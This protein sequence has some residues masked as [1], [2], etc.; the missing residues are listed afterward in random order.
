MARIA[1]L[2]A[3]LAG[4]A[5]AHRLD[6]EGH[7]VTVFEREDHI[8]GVVRTLRA[9]GFLA[10]T[11]A[12][13][14][15][16]PPAEAAA[17][18]RATRI[19]DAGLPAA[20]VSR[21]RWTLHGGHLIELPGSPPALLRARV[22]PLRARLSVLR[23]A[24]RAATPAPVDESVADLLRRRGIAR[25]LIDLLLD[26]FVGGVYAGDV[27]R[28]SARW[29]FPALHGMLAEHGSLVRGAIAGAR[30]RGRGSGS[31]SF[32]EGMGELPRRI[33]DAFGGTIRTRTP[34]E[35]VRWSGRWILTTAAGPEEADAV[36]CATPA[37]A[38]PDLL[39]DTAGEAGCELPDV[40]YNPV[41]ILTLG[42][43]RADVGHSLD[44]FGALFPT[45]AGLSTLGVLF[46]SSVFPG[47]A[48]DG[49]VSLACFVGGSRAPDAVSLPEPALQSLVLEEIAPLLD[50]RGDPVFSHRAAW[51][52]AIPQYLIGY[53]DAIGAWD[54]LEQAVPTLALCGSYRGDGI[55]IGQVLASG[56]RAAGRLS[57]RLKS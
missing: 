20:A 28:L 32:P 52:R 14:F 56:L 25:E 17:F 31:V 44:G 6:T 34:V 7:D 38:L 46:P 29:A 39:G 41:A 27:E 50:L 48:P 13:S 26:P 35:H 30:R 3:G 1:V 47:R 55:A 33:A 57:S 10:E 16:R 9:D 12:H 42:F 53:G 22:L 54:R 45:R 37:W 15:G 18:L 23:E 43:R 5:A 4:L 51:P 24:F 8:G 11:G 40:A 36:V 2:G 49:H 21:R 19:A